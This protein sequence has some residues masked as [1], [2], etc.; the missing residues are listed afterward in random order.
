MGRL[1]YM[2]NIQD[3]YRRPQTDSAVECCSVI[4]IEERKKLCS[5]YGVEISSA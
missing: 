5:L 1:V 4:V 3:Y 2:A